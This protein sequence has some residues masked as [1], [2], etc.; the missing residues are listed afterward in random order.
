MWSSVRA[1]DRPLYI[2]RYAAFARQYIDAGRHLDRQ[3]SPGTP[4]IRM[5]GHA[6]RQDRMAAGSRDAHAPDVR[7]PDRVEPAAVAARTVD[8]RLVLRPGEWQHLQH[9]GDGPEQRHDIGADLRRR[10][11]ARQ[12]RNPDADTAA[13]QPQRLVLTAPAY[14]VPSARFATLAR[15]PDA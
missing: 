12:D 11:M 4:V 2:L 14:V 10:R 9:I 15:K 7:T 1:V 5:Q 13:R 6:V 8:G 3:R